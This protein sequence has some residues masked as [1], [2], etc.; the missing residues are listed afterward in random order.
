MTPEEICN[1]I[2]RCE[3]LAGEIILSCEGASAKTKTDARNIVTEYDTRVQALLTEKLGSFLPGAHFFC[4]EGDDRDSAVKGEVFII[5]PIDGTM[6]FF[7]G[8]SASVIS[9]AYAKDGEVLAG[10]VYNPYLDEMFH[11]V[12]GKG[13]FLN[14]RRIHVT[15]EPLSDTIVAFGTSPYYLSLTRRSFALAEEMFNRSLDV[16]R[17][18]SAA[19]DACSVAAGRAG[20]YFELQ[21]SYWDYA[22]G[23]FIAREAGAA[24][25]TAEGAPLPNDGSRSSIVVGSRQNVDA[26]LAAA[27]GIS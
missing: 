16:R 24:A 13:A 27:A 22:A 8:M 10:A 1:E 5:D 4:E 3:R 11:A 23:A 6:N 18:G 15:D 19:L 2:M 14:D 12:K 9:A 20:L 17:S 26:F 21:I 7:R 25:V